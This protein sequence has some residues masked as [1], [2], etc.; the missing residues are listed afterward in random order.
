MCPTPPSP[1]PDCTSLGADCRSQEDSNS[2]LRTHELEW[3]NIGVGSFCLPVVLLTC[4]W[5]GRRV[6]MAARSVRLGDARPLASRKRYLLGLTCAE[7]ALLALNLCCYLAMNIYSI[8]VGPCQ[9]SVQQ[10]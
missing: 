4:A 1:T 5:Y 6:W 7:L 3:V 10:P 8:K 2:L 9:Q